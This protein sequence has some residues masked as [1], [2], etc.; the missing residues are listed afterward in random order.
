MANYN[1]VILVGNL[2]RDPQLR[3]TP[4]Q[5]PVCDFGLAINRQ[6]TGQDGQKHSEPTF[7]DI[8]AWARSAETINKYM[9]KGDPILI[10]GRLQTRSWEGQ[11]GQKRTKLSVVAER[12]QFLG[13]AGGARQSS[14]AG[15]SQAGAAEPSDSPQATGE[16]RNLNQDAFAGDAG[17]DMIPF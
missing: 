14:S 13:R 3:Y 6:W 1:K 10:E 9:H 7:V 15:E 17:D 5:Q 16:G 12:F 4:N 2:T 8:T 11:D